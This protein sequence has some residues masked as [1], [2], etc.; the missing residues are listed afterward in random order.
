MQKFIEQIKIQKLQENIDKDQI[1]NRLILN[2]KIYTENILK[3]KKQEIQKVNQARLIEIV[4]TY[5]HMKLK[6]KVFSILVKD[7][8]KNQSIIS[9]FRISDIQRK[10]R[11]VF[12]TFLRHCNALK[13][14]KCFKEFVPHFLHKQYRFC[15]K[16]QLFNLIKEQYLITKN[17]YLKLKKEQNQKVFEQVFYLWF[18]VTQKQIKVRNEEATKYYVLRK[19]KRIFYLWKKIKTKERYYRNIEATFIELEK[20]AASWELHK[21][22]T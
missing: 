5:Y 6:R 3:K 8:F 19:K 16:Q 22:H 12:D 18:E 1:K 4:N 11:I 13:L 20:I 2:K 9:F 21:L 7:Y 17:K 15:L 14:K 10:R